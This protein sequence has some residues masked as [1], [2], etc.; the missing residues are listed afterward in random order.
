MPSAQIKNKHFPKYYFWLIKLLYKRA[1][2]IIAQT[3][4]MEEEIIK[5]YSST[6]N[7]IIVTSNPLDEALIINQLKDQKNPYN[8]DDI[9]I[10]VSG[11][12][13]EEKGQEYFS[14]YCCTSVWPQ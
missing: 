14:N 4:E 5:Y 6:R 7:E 12:I 2:F 11:R 1:D 8:T 13:S 10:I 9:N 3:E